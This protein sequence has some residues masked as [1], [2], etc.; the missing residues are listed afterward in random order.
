V[1]CKATG[2]GRWEPK[3]SPVLDGYRPPVVG[4]KAPYELEM[5][6]EEREERR[7]RQNPIITDGEIRYRYMSRRPES[8][9][10]VLS[11][12]LPQATH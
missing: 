2:G 5:E 12:R 4:G 8:V 1:L 6:R 10:V 7:R 9:D 3:Q 11:R